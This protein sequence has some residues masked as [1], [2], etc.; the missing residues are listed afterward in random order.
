MKKFNLTTST[1][2]LLS[3]L[4][5]GACG[6]LVDNSP[7][8][9][10][11]KPAPSGDEGGSEEVVKTTDAKSFV[12]KIVG[13][14][15]VLTKSF[16]KDT[17]GKILEI[18]AKLPAMGIGSIND[19]VLFEKDSK[20]ENQLISKQQSIFAATGETPE[21]KVQTISQFSGLKIKSA[22]QLEASIVAISRQ[23]QTGAEDPMN[24]NL[25][26]SE[27]VQRPV[28]LSLSDDNLTLTIETKADAETKKANG[29]TCQMVGSILEAKK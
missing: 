14:P 22:N 21:V 28:T 20:T 2:S 29:E 10:D 18:E 27:K 23:T 8:L 16:C 17:D 3:V 19:S 1:L 26:E 5:L 13:N 4:A 9:N 6:V 7:G 12:D 24:D 11:G 15:F 25:V